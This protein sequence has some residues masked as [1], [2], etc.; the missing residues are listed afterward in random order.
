[1]EMPQAGLG[2][3][4]VCPRKRYGWLKGVYAIQC[5]CFI[6][7]QPNFG[8]SIN[9]FVYHKS[10]ILASF[11]CRVQLNILIIMTHLK[12]GDS[13]P[14]FTGKD[15]HGNTIS[16][17]DY[18]GKK[19]V[20]YFYPKD[21]TPGC[22]AQACNLRD[23]YSELQKAGY[24]ILGVSADTE[25]KHQKFIEKYDLPF[26]LIAD[27]EKEVIQAF[28]V[29]GQKKFM[30]REYDGIHRETFVIDE[31]GKILKVVEKV[32]TKDHTAQIIE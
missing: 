8:F 21:D 3:R 19:L 2:A 27:T 7:K 11:E 29:W 22:T 28:G 5:L 17:S 20:V 30:G 16:L 13:A 32:K 18:K 6:N 23:N 9:T 26:P 1:M 24:E 14:N 25:K 31:E 10:R 15:Q 12:P 4:S